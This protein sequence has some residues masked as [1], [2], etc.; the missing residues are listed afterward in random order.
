MLCDR[1]IMRDTVSLE[2]ICMYE[3]KPLS[4]SHGLR[5]FYSNIL[6]DLSVW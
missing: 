3:E 2:A 6:P 4:I 5:L 1:K